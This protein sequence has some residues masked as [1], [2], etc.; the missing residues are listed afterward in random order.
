MNSLTTYEGLAAVASMKARV[1]AVDWRE[2][3]LAIDAAPKNR[4]VEMKFVK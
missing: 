2:H 4:R 3:M 1:E